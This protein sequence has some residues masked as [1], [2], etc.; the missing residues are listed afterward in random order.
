MVKATLGSIPEDVV[1]IVTGFL[2]KG[3]ESGAITT[4]GR[5]GSDLTA[6][7][8]GASLNLKEIH[9][10][11]DVDGVLTADPWIVQ[12]AKAVPQVTFEEASELAFFGA[13]ILHPLSMKPAMD[14]NIPVRVRNSYN[15]N[16]M[17]TLISDTRRN[18]LAVTSLVEKSH[19][20]LVDIKSTAM[21]NV[22]GFMAKVFNIFD[23]EEISVDVV[24]TSEVSI[25]LTLDPSQFK[26]GIPEEHYENAI[27]RLKEFADVS[28]NTDMCLVSIIC[29]T[30]HSA[31]ILGRAGIKLS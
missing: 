27:R 19:V 26:G 29:K 15:V 13:E 3:Q 11:K 18:D 7:I 21:L 5:G 17:G 23:E 1:P 31:E 8:I 24:A 28:T 25:S 14:Y 22:P 20:T 4:L 12:H 16:A 6:S 9:V 10:W 30:T 2:A